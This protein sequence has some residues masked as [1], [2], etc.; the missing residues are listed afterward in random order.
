[1]LCTPSAPIAGLKEVPLVS[2]LFMLSKAQMRR[3]E[4]YFVLSHAIPRIDDRRILIG[5][6]FVNR[7]GLRWRD[8]SLA[9]SKLLAAT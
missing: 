2:D 1:M 6:I 9:S 3:I 7:N 4:S 8:T 5:I